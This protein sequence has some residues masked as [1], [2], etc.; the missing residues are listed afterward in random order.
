MSEATAEKG[1]GPRQKSHSMC[2]PAIISKNTLEPPKF[3]LAVFAG[4]G[5]ATHAAG[6][7][8]SESAAVQAFPVVIA[9]CKVVG[10]PRWIAKLA[11]YAR[12][13]AVV[14]V[15]V[16]VSTCLGADLEFA[17]RFASAEHVAVTRVVLLVGLG[18][19]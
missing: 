8:L 3:I 16:G 13:R 14:V 17:A 6:G 11:L 19:L 7:A 1:F 18:L 9:A 15:A 12:T 10:A 2:L 4:K 5:F